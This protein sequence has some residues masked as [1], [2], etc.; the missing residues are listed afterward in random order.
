ME[1]VIGEGKISAVISLAPSNVSVG[2]GAYAAIANDH[3]LKCDL[4][5]TGFSHT[6][7]GSLADRTDKYEFNSDVCRKVHV[8]N[9]IPG[10]NNEPGPDHS[11]DNTVILTN[12]SA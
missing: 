4:E 7:Y 11:C 12:D 8:R 10:I 3:S 9:T 1:T 5:R 2:K 6:P